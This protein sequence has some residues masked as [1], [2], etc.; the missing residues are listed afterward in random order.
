MREGTFPEQHNRADDHGC[1]ANTAA[2]LEYEVDFSIIT[3]PAMVTHSMAIGSENM[4]AGKK[5]PIPSSIGLAKLLLSLVRPDH[6]NRRKR[7]PIHNPGSAIEHMRNSPRTLGQREMSGFLKV[8]KYLECVPQRQ[9]L[10]NAAIA[11]NIPR[12]MRL[13]I[14]P[15]GHSFREGKE[16]NA[17]HECIK[18]GTGENH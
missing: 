17:V 11:P 1:H 6:A 15:C 14:S 7:I 10:P 3:R 9:A 18:K 16:D 2:R 8:L 13:A 4:N 5:E 12:T